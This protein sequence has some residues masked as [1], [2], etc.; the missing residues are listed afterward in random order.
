M[1][2]VDGLY[3]DNAIHDVTWDGLARD[4]SVPQLLD[5]LFTTGSYRSVS[6]ALNSAGVQLDESM[7]DFR[8]PPALR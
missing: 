3:R 8:F 5:V 6:Y 1:R 4:L 2:A 7:A